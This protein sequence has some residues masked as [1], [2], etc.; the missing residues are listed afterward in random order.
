MGGSS[1]D[2]FGYAGTDYSRIP[3]PGSYSQVDFPDNYAPTPKPDA[4]FKYDY[5]YDYEKL[6][7][8]SQDIEKIRLRIKGQQPAT[9]SAL[10]DHWVKVVQMLD[11]VKT[12]VGDNADA[13]HGGDSNG[14][15]GWSS[16]AADEFLRWGPGATL[17]SLQQWTD[18]AQANV[19]AL[20]KLADAVWQAHIDIDQAWTSYVEEARA[21]RAKLME[22]WTWDPSELSKEDQKKLPGPPAQLM[23]Q[24]YEHQ[25]A[26]WRKWSVTA[27][28]ISYELSQKYYAQLE[29]DLIA[30]RGTRFEGPGN[31]VVDNPMTKAFTPPGGA[32]PPAAPPPGAAPPPAPPPAAPP[33]GATPPPATPTPTP[34]APPSLQ[35]LTDLADQLQQQAFTAPPAPIDAPVIA[36]LPLGEL[37]LSAETARLIGLAPPAPANSGLFGSRPGAAPGLPGDAPAGNPGVL[38]SGAVARPGETPPGGM[39]R[40]LSRPG[41][42]RPGAN[43]PGTEPGSGRRAG[44]RD[45]DQ[46]RVARTGGLEEPFEGR[47]PSASPSVL[48]GRRT[49]GTPEEPPLR[50][51]GTSRP[52]RS[53]S[54]VQRSEGRPASTSAGETTGEPGTSGPVLSSPGAA[55]ARGAVAP[56]GADDTPAVRGLRSGTGAGQ[57]AP[58]ELSARRRA[59]ARRGDQRR[60]DG[61]IGTA[62]DTS[63]SDETGVVGDEAWTVPS[64]GGSLL[65]SRADQPAYEAEHRP[66]LGGGGS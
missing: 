3:I 13:L 50:A 23:S 44:A 39:G 11:A 45:A 15:G 26:I 66:A 62:G 60:A 36:P 12:A 2:D 49:T 30:G 63:D 1:N 19:R 59:D 51:P 61:G 8:A 4:N 40:A 38:R 54:V 46:G 29:G 5:D 64:P 41:A 42:N 56:A 24:I 9:I 10:A 35:D 43:R 27:Q 18:A 47:T 53:P 28:G 48:G 55:R 17:Y 22:G 58:S 57:P 25:T 33:P 37:A 34:T 52:G 20:R 7:D 32:P 31:A 21:D 65:T 14:F 6:S 16:P